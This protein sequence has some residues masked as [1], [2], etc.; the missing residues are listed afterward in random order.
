MIPNYCPGATYDLGHKPCYISWP[1][2]GSHHA[3]LH[4]PGAY[5]LHVTVWQSMTQPKF[6][7][8]APDVCWPVNGSHNAAMHDTGAYFLHKNLWHDSQPYLT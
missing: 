3:A 8:G 1:V 2:Y 7:V 5:F 4:D 6:R